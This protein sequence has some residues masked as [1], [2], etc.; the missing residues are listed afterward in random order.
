MAVLYLED[1]ALEERVCLGSFT[2][3]EEAVTAFARKYDPQPFHLD[4]AAAART[5]YGKLIASGWHTASVWMK[6]MVAHRKEEARRGTEYGAGVSPGFL[7]LN[8]KHPVFIGDTVTY[9]TTAIEKVP[10]KSKPGWGLLRSRNEGLN[11]NG[12]EVLR[13]IGQGFMRSKTAGGEDA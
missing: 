7:D 13:F 3:S 2:F 1:V 5:P 11:Q 4:P 6:L 9:Y 10:L 12:Q 8:W